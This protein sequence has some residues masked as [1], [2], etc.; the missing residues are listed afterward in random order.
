MPPK[1]TNFPGFT[2]IGERIFVREGEEAA[3][4][5]SPPANHPRAII[6]F[7]WGDANPKH[8]AKFTDA[9]RKFFPH[10]KQIAILSPIFKVIVESV[11]T[12]RRGMK[13]VIDAAYP[14]E[15]LGTATEDAVLVQSM[16]NAGAIT[17]S[18][19]LDAY[20]E[21]HGKSMP[22]RL[23]VW[24]STPG[25]PMM[26]WATLKRWSNATAMGL[27]PLVP[28]PYIVTQL[29]AGL[30]LALLRA[31]QLAIGWVPAPVFAGNTVRDENFVAIHTRHLFLYGRDD[32]IIAA[33]EIEANIAASRAKGYVDDVVRFEGSD[34][35]A[36]MRM[37]PEKYWGE[38]LASWKKAQ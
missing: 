24:D 3:D 10:A 35:V 4:G 37:F 6:L 17:Y 31:Y 16:S 11:E 26:T 18:A 27:A 9:Y 14:P 8:V 33:H 19:A 1:P 22:H 23:T 15:V 30:V 25:D 36:H 7:S 13:P 5:A 34:H 28:L 21:R 20:R 12:R 29:L 32:R 38:V 2:A